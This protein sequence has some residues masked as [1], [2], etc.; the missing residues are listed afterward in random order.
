[1]GVNNSIMEVT[2]LSCNNKINLNSA[3]QILSFALI[4]L[5]LFQYIC[6]LARL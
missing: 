1:M 6:K 3:S 4:I 5:K 2:D